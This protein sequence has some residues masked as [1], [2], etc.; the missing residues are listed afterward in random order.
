[1]LTAPSPMSVCVLASDNFRFRCGLFFDNVVAAGSLQDLHDERSEEAVVGDMM[2]FS[3]LSISDCF[4]SVKNCL[5]SALNWNKTFPNCT[6]SSSRSMCWRVTSSHCRR[7]TLNSPL[8]VVE[9]LTKVL[10]FVVLL[11][12]I[13]IFV[14]HTHI[15]TSATVSTFNLTDQSYAIFHIKLANPIIASAVQ[16]D[17][18]CPGRHLMGAKSTFM[19]Q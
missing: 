7:T 19:E 15:N 5:S 17:N 8:C 4:M 1:M 10:L 16:W 13:L 12:L 18:R 14:S 3:T 9:K 6:E 2:L 11:I